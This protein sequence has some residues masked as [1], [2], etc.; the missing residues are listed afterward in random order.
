MD[1]FLWKYANKYSD[2]KTEA[3]SKTEARLKLRKPGIADYLS[4]QDLLKIAVLER[5]SRII[6]N[7]NGEHLL[8][9]LIAKQLESQEIY[10]LQLLDWL[11]EYADPLETDEGRAVIRESVLTD[12]RD[13][14]RRE[15][16]LQELYARHKDKVR[17]DDDGQDA[18]GFF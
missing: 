3:I 10:E 8:Q 16:A 5:V 4:L 1:Y 7:S 13:R 11:Q 14:Y 6:P 15:V 17:N 2:I 12:G 18:S 9:S